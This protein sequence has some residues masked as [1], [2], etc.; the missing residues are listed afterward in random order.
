[1]ETGDSGQPIVVAD[2]ESSAA[3][4]MAKIAQ[5]VGEQAGAAAAH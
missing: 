2:P 3:R 4:A 1:M 5:R